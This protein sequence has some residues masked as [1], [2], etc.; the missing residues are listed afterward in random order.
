VPTEVRE[1]LKPA[2][3]SLLTIFLVMAALYFGREVF[4]PLALAALLS[5]LLVPLSAR[6]ER[7]G[8]PRAFASLLVV[9]LSLA[10]VATL[11]W[12]MLGQVYNLA[13]ELPQYEQNINQKIDA[14]HLHSAGRLSNTLAMLSNEMRQLRGGTPPPTAVPL[15]PDPPRRRTRAKTTAPET[16]SDSNKVQLSAPSD[17]PV[18]VR[19]EEPEESVVNLANRTLTPLIHPV[20]TTFVVVIFLGFML[21]GREDLRDRCI[22]LAGRGRMQVTTSTIEDAGRR[23]GRYLRMQLVVNITLGGVAGLLLWA[24]GV[25]NPLLWALLIALLRFVPYIGILMA[26]AGPVLLAIAVS[27][28]WGT[29]LWTAFTLLVLEFVTGNIAEPLLYGS[30]TGLSPI[31]VLIAAIFW[32]LLWG[33]PGLLLSTPLT[34][35]LVVIG[36]QVPRLQFLEVLLG[37]ENALPPSERLY[38]R[39]LASNTHEARALLETQLATQPREAVFDS[40]VVPAL[41]ML[42]E[43]RHA[44]EL[45]NSRAEELLQSIEEIVEEIVSRAPMPPS[46]VTHASS[47][48]IACIPA[49]DF[50]DEIACELASHILTPASIVRAF[51]AESSASDIFEALDIVRADV[52]CVVGVPPSSL[53]HIRLRCRQVR[54]RFPDAI[55]FACVLSE[56]CDLPNIRSRIPTEDAQHVVCSLAKLN[57]YLSS[58]LNPPLLP[59]EPSVAP[60][61]EAA[62]VQEESPDPLAEVQHIDAIDESNEDVFQRLTADLARA[63]EAPIALTTAADG[64]RLFWEAHCGLPDEALFNSDN[65]R[66]GRNCA[67]LTSSEPLLVIPDTAEDSR[68][69][70]DPFFIERGIRFYAGTPLKS[71]DGSIIGALCVLDTRPRQITDK[72]KELLIWIAEAVTTA[73]ELQ[74]AEPEPAEPAP[75]LQS[76]T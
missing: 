14:L 76:E 13:I 8:L 15:I 26:S 69:A 71:H 27:P 17:Q 67:C 46:P 16:T 35:C 34:V 4:V 72:Q 36:R 54:A 52:I 9:F 38:Q 62:E 18:T 55:V 51:P 68:T 37:D 1:A 24:L 40:V 28:H 61:K 56:Q 66:L 22:R 25:P 44:D 75:A 47:R 29:F 10:A 49:R 19:I 5:F 32:T 7:W 30:S 2:S 21:I 53:R 42:E 60:A 41:T 65:T 50:A 31:A 58:L 59:A 11:G 39:L 3:T 57:E 73:I 23:V 12:V 43:S 45:T 63:F 6:L 64:E 70:Q 74:N 33:L 48:F 20:T